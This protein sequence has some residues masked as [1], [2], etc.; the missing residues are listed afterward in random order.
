MFDLQVLAFQAD[1]TRVITFQIAREVS[2]RTYPQIGVPD[3][4]H[5]ISHH[6]LDPVKMA[7]LAKISGYHVSL[8]GYF[9]DKLKATQDGEGTLL[10]NSLL[11]LGSGLGN[12]D[13][14]DHTNL[15]VLVAGGGS[16]THRGGRHIV[17]NPLTPMTN[18]LLTMLDKSGVNVEKFADSTG[19]IEELL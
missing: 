14:H 11:L 1:I 19:K 18:V 7:K 8:F 12:P 10:D 6:Q 13:V 4:H 16:G 2:T 3:A 9:L 15:P 5:P 17:C